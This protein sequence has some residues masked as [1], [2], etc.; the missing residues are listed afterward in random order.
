MCHITEF[1]GAGCGER[2]KLAEPALRGTVALSHF[3]RQVTTNNVKRGSSLAR[4]A[5]GLLLNWGSAVARGWKGRDPYAASTD[6]GVA[7]LNNSV[8]MSM[9]LLVWTILDLDIIL[10]G[11]RIP[12]VIH[13]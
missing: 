7:V 6:A 4:L 13:L 10:F 8:P 11:K 12:L 9:G 2:H 5:Q 3:G 1:D